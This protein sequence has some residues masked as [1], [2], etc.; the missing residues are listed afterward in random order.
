MT[1]RPGGTGQKPPLFNVAIATRMSHHF[2]LLAVQ[3]QQRGQ[4]A[5]DGGGGG[6]GGGGEGLGARADGGLAPQ[7]RVLVCLLVVGDV[8]QAWRGERERGGRE[9]GRE[10]RQV[11][12]GE[13]EIRER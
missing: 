11:R 9:K 7:A 5:A 8:L 12:E 1:G 6:G 3:L 2:P 13:R 10:T 4:L